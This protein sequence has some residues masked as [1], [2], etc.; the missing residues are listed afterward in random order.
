MLQ[1]DRLALLNKVSDK[2]KHTLRTTSIFSDVREAVS[3]IEFDK[4]AVEAQE[5]MVWFTL[6]TDDDYT[7]HLETIGHGLRTFFTLW[8]DKEVLF[9][10][11]NKNLID[12]IA[13]IKE[14]MITGRNDE[15]TC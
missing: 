11:G 14:E 3:E 4:C 1:A 2:E 10:G 12:I 8:K 13:F 15:P 6:K 7:I 5:D 9:A